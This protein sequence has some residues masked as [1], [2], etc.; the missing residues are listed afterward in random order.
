MYP[1]IDAAA[2]SLNIKPDD[3]LLPQHHAALVALMAKDA[4]ACCAAGVHTPLTTKPKICNTCACCAAANV[5]HYERPL[6]FGLL[7]L[8]MSVDNGLLTPKVMSHTCAADPP[9]M[10]WG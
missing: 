4:D 1:N 8:L 5:K 3:V 9:L 6:Q 7:P 10:S 2:Q